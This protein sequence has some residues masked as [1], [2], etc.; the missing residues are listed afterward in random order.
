MAQA[1]T[2]ESVDVVVSD[3]TRQ[4]RFRA[5]NVKGNKTIGE[6]IK[7]V[8]PKLGLAARDRNGEPISFRVRHQNGRNLFPSEKVADAVRSGEEVTL[9]RFTVAG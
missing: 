6:L 3:V 9:E 2:A 5:K 1:A 7:G 8:L 4:R